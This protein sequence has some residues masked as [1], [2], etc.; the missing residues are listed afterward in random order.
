M[1]FIT[2]LGALAQV[3]RKEAP[4][5]MGRTYKG[6]FAVFA[7]I[8]GIIFFWGMAIVMLWAIITGK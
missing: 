5:P 2:G 4:G 8:V 3:I 7:G 1:S 6:W